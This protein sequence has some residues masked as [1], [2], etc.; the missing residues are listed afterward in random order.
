MQKFKQQEHALCC[1]ST[2]SGDSDHLPDDLN[3]NVWLVVGSGA[4]VIEVLA[5][6]AA[7]AS[8]PDPAAAAGEV[9]FR[10]KSK[11]NC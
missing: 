9:T 2:E 6:S 1:A 3:Q 7:H 5:L 8:S 10:P 11:L 4:S